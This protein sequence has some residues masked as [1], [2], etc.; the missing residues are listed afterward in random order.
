[1]LGFPFFRSK[2]SVVAD[3]AAETTAKS[4]GA[5][6][7]DR[8]PWVIREWSGPGSIVLQSQDPKH[9]ASLILDGVFDD[10]DQRYAYASA[11]VDWLNQ[12]LETAQI[13]HV[14]KAPPVTAADFAA[15]RIDND[16]AGLGLAADEVEP[17]YIPQYP[18][19][20]GSLEHAA[21]Q[22]LES[23]EIK[24]APDAP[25]AV[26]VEPAVAEQPIGLLRQATVDE[27][28]QAAQTAA[29]PSVAAPTL[30]EKVTRLLTTSSWPMR[31][32]SAA[33]SP[34]SVEPKLTE[35]T[36]DDEQTTQ[37]APTEA[38][39]QL[40]A[41]GSKPAKSRDVR[42]AALRKEAEEV[43]AVDPMPPLEPAHQARSA[44]AVT[45]TPREQVTPPKPQRAPQKWGCH[46]D[47][48]PGQQPDS[49][50]IDLDQPEYCSIASSGVRKEACV[51]WQPIQIIRQAA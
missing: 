26:V 45:A 22:Q 31:K 39:P 49:C 33:P 2:K 12:Q 5:S 48:Q 17:T 19:A 1:M 8:G 13:A 6:A 37:L 27:P 46:C 23:L 10:M 16:M 36:M 9:E 32:G 14:Q 41:V 20:R 44:P 47:L 40:A 21:G 18:I 28:P 30:T 38:A 34:R 35:P 42:R 24:S 3:Q 11:M 4:P 50:V 25:S 29:A 51:H 7:P 15:H 43:L